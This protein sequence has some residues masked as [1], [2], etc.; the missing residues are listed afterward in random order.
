[1]RAIYFYSR[2]D[3]SYVTIRPFSSPLHPLPSPLNPLGVS[4]AR[5]TP[6]RFIVV[7]WAVY[8]LTHRCRSL[9]RSF[10]VCRSGFLNDL[11]NAA[12]GKLLFLFKSS[13][14]REM[15]KEVDFVWRGRDIVERG[16]QR[17]ISS[18]SL[19]ST[20]FFKLRY[21]CCC[22]VLLLSSF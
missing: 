13:K 15:G 12:A 18:V 5:P 4:H 19:S 2:Y 8:L 16:G 21:C 10:L 3:L 9:A 17:R 11:K 20:F 7:L 22:T 1:M 6:D 14:E